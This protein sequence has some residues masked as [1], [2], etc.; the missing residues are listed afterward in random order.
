MSMELPG[1]PGSSIFYCRR[2]SIYSV[3]SFTEPSIPSLL[4]FRETS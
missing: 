1:R 4:L 3:S 2:L